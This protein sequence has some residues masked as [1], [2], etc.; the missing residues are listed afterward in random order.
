MSDQD[1]CNRLLTGRAHALQMCTNCN[2]IGHET[3]ACPVSASTAGKQ[4]DRARSPEREK[5]ALP[6]AKCRAPSSAQAFVGNSTMKE[7]AAMRFASFA[8]SARYARGATQEFTALSM[9]TRGY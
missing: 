4:F 5:V 1:L 3:N 8:M 9:A 6:L 7:V 2:H